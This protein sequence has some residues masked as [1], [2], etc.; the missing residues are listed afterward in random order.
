MKKE[1][2]RLLIKGIPTICFL[3]T[4]LARYI[5]EEFK[6]RGLLELALIF[7]SSGGFLIMF[8]HPFYLAFCGYKEKRTNFFISYFEMIILLL[9]YF[10]GINK[11]DSFSRDLKRLIC[12]CEYTYTTIL[13][14]VVYIV[15]RCKRNLSEKGSIVKSESVCLKNGVF[16]LL[17]I[18]PFLLA[19]ALQCILFYADSFSGLARDM[20]YILFLSEELVLCLA[21]GIYYSKVNGVLIGINKK[22]VIMSFTM[23]VSGLFFQY[24]LCLLGG[25]DS[26]FFVWIFV[27]STILLISCGVVWSNEYKARKAEH[28]AEAVE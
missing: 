2:K 7:I 27:K 11:G 1:M 16:I 9:P 25:S 4:L 6:T 18:S 15:K 8:I 21:G 10:I 26:Q 3:L 12:T 24:F 14:I 13:W 22:A 23:A 20:I 28:N 17:N 19:C 5:E